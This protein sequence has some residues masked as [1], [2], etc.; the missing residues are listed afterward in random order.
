MA[1][2][3]LVKKDSQEGF[4]SMSQEQRPALERQSNE[5][6][7]NAIE[8]AESLR[9]AI[10]SC[11]DISAQARQ[12]Q[13]ILQIAEAAGSFRRLSGMLPPIHKL[14]NP[15]PLTDHVR[16]LS[17]HVRAQEANMRALA[18]PAKALPPLNSLAAF[19]VTSHLEKIG[20]HIEETKDAVLSVRGA[21]NVQTEKVN[22][23]QEE[24]RLVRYSGNRNASR[25]RG[26]IDRIERRRFELQ[27]P[28]IC[29]GAAIGALATRAL[30]WLVG[31][32]F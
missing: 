15:F 22:Q 5:V 4:E 2:L 1:N 17:E 25:A 26:Q 14:E 10:P 13:N 9:A 32:I 30:D 31:R 27:V 6:L 20:E 12:Y 18:L 16:Y 11:I 7:R 8:Q 23:V 19:P 28:Q 21:V 3:A 24:I 29:F